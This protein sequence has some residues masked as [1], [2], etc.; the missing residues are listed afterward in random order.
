MKKQEKENAQLH[1]KWVRQIAR[2]EIQE[3]IKEEAMKW[4]VFAP[5]FRLG[6]HKTS[7]HKKA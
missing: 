5:D 1:E 6:K 3:Y 7:K 2:E 4:P